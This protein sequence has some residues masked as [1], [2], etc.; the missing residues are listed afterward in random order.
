VETVEID[1]WTALQGLFA[2]KERRGF[3]LIDPP[4]EEPANSK[5]F[6]MGS[7]RGIGAGRRDLSALVPD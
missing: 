2:A 3:V 1:G 6:A 7:S 4:F 5:G